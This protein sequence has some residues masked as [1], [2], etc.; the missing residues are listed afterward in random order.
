MILENCWIVLLEN[1]YYASSTTNHRNIYVLCF[2][3]D[4]PIV[5]LRTD[6][7]MPFGAIMVL[8]NLPFLHGKIGLTVGILVPQCGTSPTATPT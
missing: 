4:F 1:Y 7:G 5:I 6:F 2:K 8:L 3:I